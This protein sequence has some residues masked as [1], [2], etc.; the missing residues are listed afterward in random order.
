MRRK[1][2]WVRYYYHASTGTILQCSYCGY[3]IKQPAKL[4]A[5]CNKCKSE[6]GGKILSEK[7]GPISS[8]KQ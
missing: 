4:P 8:N 5:E 2:D 3:I 6:M 7:H 1:A